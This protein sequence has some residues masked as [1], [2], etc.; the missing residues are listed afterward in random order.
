MGDEVFALD[1]DRVQEI[2][3]VPGVTRV[4]HVAGHVLGVCNL[5]GRI[6][7]VMELR[8]LMRMPSRPLDRLSRILVLDFGGKQIGMLVDRANEVAH[9]R[10]SDIEPPPEEVRSV[11]RN[12][13]TAVARLNARMVFILDLDQVLAIK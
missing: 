9:I 2:I 13:V 3:R 1:I 12:L 6:V 11:D 8:K 7:P 4:P 5:R 10:V